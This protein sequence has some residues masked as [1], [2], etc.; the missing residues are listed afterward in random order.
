MTVARP[1]DVAPKKRWPESTISWACICLGARR[2]RRKRRPPMSATS[3]AAI[4]TASGLS[5]LG[6]MLPVSVTGA[7]LPTPCPLRL[8]R[9]LGHD[10]QSKLCR[11][12][13]STIKL[14][15]EMAVRGPFDGAGRGH[16][17]AV[18]GRYFLPQQSEDRFLACARPRCVSKI[19]I[20]KSVIRVAAGAVRAGIERDP[21]TGLHG[22]AFHAFRGRSRGAA[23]QPRVPRHHFAGRRHQ[24]RPRTA[25]RRRRR[26]GRHETD[27]HR[28]R[29]TLR[30]GCNS[31]A[32]PSAQPARPAC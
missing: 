9:P 13:F 32:S 2:R 4:R 5:N 27:P 12:S 11:N 23:V 18:G 26:R 15:H 7:R 30:P 6:S 8:C 10:S 25:R 20:G 31:P 28:A 21:E 14:A 16:H 24:Q 17:S 19:L 29:A 3:A 1:P 22:R